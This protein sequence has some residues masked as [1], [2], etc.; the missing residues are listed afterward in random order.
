M[1]F[2]R[3]SISLLLMYQVLTILPQY[4]QPAD[5]TT[6]GHSYARD[7]KFTED[8]E[9]I[10]CDVIFMTRFFLEDMNGTIADR[11]TLESVERLVHHPFVHTTCLTKDGN[12]ISAHKWE[13]NRWEM[14]VSITIS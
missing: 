7:V 4:N 10:C 14:R 6:F 8:Y 5:E 11:F 3:T 13:N 1:Y 9:N 12:T 2:G